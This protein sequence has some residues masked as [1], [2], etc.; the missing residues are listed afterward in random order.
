[1]LRPTYAITL[2]LSGALTRKIE[3]KIK[4]FLGS[5][6]FTIENV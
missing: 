4:L 1:M 5:I 6:F 2:Q 3:F